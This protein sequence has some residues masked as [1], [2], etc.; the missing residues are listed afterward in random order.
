MARNIYLGGSAFFVLL[1][2]ALTF[3]TQSRAMPERDNRD[4]LTASGRI[5]RRGGDELDLDACLER[6][7]KHHQ[8][9]G[10]IDQK[11]F[12]RCL[13]SQRDL[14]CLVL[15]DISLSTETHINNQQR[16]IDVAQGGLL[17][18]SEAL[19]ASRDPFA[20]FA[21]SSRRSCP[22]NCPSSTST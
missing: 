15:A 16:V 19:Q 11:L 1:F 4:Q 20:V 14:A 10:E 18:L 7:V 3:D 9:R 8:G 17:L 12:H 6:A 13:Q 2:L 22:C 5:A 21:F